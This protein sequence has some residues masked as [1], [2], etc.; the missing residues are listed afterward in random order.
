MKPQ[1]KEEN[2]ANCKQM[3][4]TIKLQT[5]ESHYASAKQ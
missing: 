5:N 1:T 4:N 2:D 3:K